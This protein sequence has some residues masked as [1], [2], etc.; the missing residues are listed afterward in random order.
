[1]RFFVNSVAEGGFLLLLFKVLE[2]MA[3]RQSCQPYQPK[4]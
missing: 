4:N 3:N 1:M 2:K